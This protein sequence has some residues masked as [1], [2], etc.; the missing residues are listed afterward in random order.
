M[1]LPN[2]LLAGGL[3]G[4]PAVAGTTP[5]FGTFG[6]QPTAV[7]AFGQTSAG[8]G[9]FGNT[10]SVAKPLFGGVCC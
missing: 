3:F 7:S 1:C 2:S 4:K 5:G 8:G 6:Q 10:T 9:L